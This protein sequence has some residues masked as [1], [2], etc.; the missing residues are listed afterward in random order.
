VGQRKAPVRGLTG[1]M[2]GKIRGYDASLSSF[3]YQKPAYSNM[4][5]SA[6]EPGEFAYMNKIQQDQKLGI[7]R[8]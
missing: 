2:N 5:F 3:G 7:I 6:G 4:S 1:A 8:N